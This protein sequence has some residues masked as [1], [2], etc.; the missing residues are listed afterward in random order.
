MTPLDFNCEVPATPGA[1]HRKARS[2]SNGTPDQGG[3]QGLAGPPPHSWQGPGTPFYSIMIS[4]PPVS[5][6]TASANEY[7]E[8][9]RF[10]HF[11]DRFDHL[12]L[13]AVHPVPGRIVAILVNIHLPLS[14]HAAGCVDDV[15]DL[16]LFGWKLFTI[17]CGS[18]GLGCLFGQEQASRRQDHQESDTH[19][20]ERTC[21]KSAL[22]G[23]YKAP[24]AQPHRAGLVCMLQYAAEYAESGFAVFR[25][26]TRAPAVNA[27]RRGL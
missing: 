4:L 27:E 17:E 7:A 20:G 3:R 13:G 15:Y 6:T 18:S 2:G 12:G 9:V 5:L 11:H 21:A 19:S 16:C 8:P 22:T 10:I 24:P 26:R 25:G 23:V 14:I 1:E